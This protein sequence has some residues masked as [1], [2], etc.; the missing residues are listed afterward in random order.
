MSES[1][2]PITRAQQYAQRAF[3]K[4]L[5]Q[6]KIPKDQRDKYSGFAKRFPTLVHSC[7]LAQALAFAQAKAP[8]SYLDDLSFVLNR[9][10]RQLLF[11]KSR[12]AEI[13]EY[14]QLSREAIAAAGWLKRY[15]EALMDDEDA[16]EGGDH[17]SMS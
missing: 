1:T 15:T 12:E 8:S 6:A 5:I 10:D 16:R 9:G 7:G 2:S 4:V 13:P 14:I 17:A 3:D 11:E